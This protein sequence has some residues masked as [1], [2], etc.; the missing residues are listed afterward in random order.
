MIDR[1]P[2]LA[3]GAMV[4]DVVGG[5]GAVIHAVERNV[6]AFE[7]LTEHVILRALHRPALHQSTLCRVDQLQPGVEHVDAA[8]H[9]PA[10]QKLCFTPRPK[11]VVL[12][13]AGVPA[14]AMLVRREAPASASA[15]ATCT[16]RVDR[17]DRA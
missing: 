14:A 1:T 2:S 12:K 6:G 13:P 3:H 5:I 15:S 8:T 10:Y 9:I 11:S 7:L 17:L 4:A 16:Y